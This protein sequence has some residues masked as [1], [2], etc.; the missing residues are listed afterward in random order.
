MKH[1][2]NKMK[3]IVGY[4]ELGSFMFALMKKIVKKFAI[5]AVAAVIAVNFVS[6]APD[7]GTG[8]DALPAGCNSGTISNLAIKECHDKTGQVIDIVC[9]PTPNANSRTTETQ[10]CK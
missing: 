9:I 8:T 5:T 3:I 10:D 6:A 2:C 4:L 7:V 1:E